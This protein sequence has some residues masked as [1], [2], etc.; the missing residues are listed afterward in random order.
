M[1]SA[2]QAGFFAHGED[3]L[4]RPSFPDTP[5]TRPIDPAKETE[6]V[7]NKNGGGGG[8][9]LPPLDGLILALVK[10]LPPTG[11]TEWKVQN[12]VMWLQMVAM[13]FQMAYGPVEPIEIKS[14]DQSQVKEASQTALSEEG[15]TANGA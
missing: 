5:S 10:K 9:D 12:R 14:T 11:T 15:A 8:D 13:A 2:R 3:R 7:K 6:K 1:R 4:V